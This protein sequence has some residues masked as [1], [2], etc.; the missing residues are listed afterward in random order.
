M[1]P[2]TVLA[3]ASVFALAVASPDLAKRQNNAA[4]LSSISSIAAQITIPASIASDFSAVPST[5]VAAVSNPT[6]LAQIYTQIE[7]GQTPAWFLALPAEAQAYLI[8]LGPKIQ[9]LIALEASA[10]IIPTSG[11]AGTGTGAV[12]STAYS[13]STVT[14]ASLSASKATTSGVSASTTKAATASSSGGASSSSSKAGAQP[15]GAIAAGVVGAAGFLG[16]VMAL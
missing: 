12:T 1:Y 6:E 14:T 9:T 10:G 5:V 16:L 8:S 4:L 15:T 3:V 11:A 13:N 7:D 2:S